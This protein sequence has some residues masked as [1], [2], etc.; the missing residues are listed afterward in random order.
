[1][2]LFRQNMVTTMK[3]SRLL[4]TVAF[5]AVANGER[6]LQRYFSLDSSSFQNISSYLTAL[7]TAAVDSSSSSGSSSSATFREQSRVSF[8][9]DTPMEFAE[10]GFR[11]PFMSQS[12]QELYISP[13]GGL[14]F[15]ADVPCSCCFMVRS[16]HPFLPLFII[17]FVLRWF[18]LQLL[19]GV[20]EHVRGA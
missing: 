19:F 17:F 11:F 10:L 18:A 9:D 5:L 7:N 15:D 2:E 8:H 12:Y 14:S 20:I 6:Y 13:N 3:G 4:L 16:R 1:M